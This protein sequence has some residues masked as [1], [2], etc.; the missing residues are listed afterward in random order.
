MIQIQKIAYRI[1][2][3]D[4]VFNTKAFFF[5]I[6]FWEKQELW[7]S[8]IYL[9]SIVKVN[10]KLMWKVKPLLCRI[11]SVLEHFTWYLCLGNF[12]L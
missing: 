6:L 2:N 8:G 12:M 1:L 3:H 5:F 10:F 7:S 4:F 9:C 11:K